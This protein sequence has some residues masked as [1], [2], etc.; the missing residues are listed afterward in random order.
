MLPSNSRYLTIRD[1]HRTPLSAPSRHNLTIM[2]CSTTIERKHPITKSLIYKPIKRNRQVRPPS[3]PRKR[4]DA[5]AKF[6][7]GNHRHI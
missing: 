6:T 2:A 5:I 1:A 3:T 7:Q 4:F